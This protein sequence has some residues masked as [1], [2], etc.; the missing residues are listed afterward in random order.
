MDIYSL[1]L[2][3]LLALCAGIFVHGQSQTKPPKKPTAAPTPSSKP[4]SNNKNSQLPFLTVYALVMAS[5]WLQGPFLYPLYQDEHHL[6][7]GLISALFTTGFLSGAV[8]GAFIGSLA[9]KYGR[10]KACLF[11]CLSYA[12]SCLFTAFP[13][14]GGV[15]L[16]SKGAA[17]VFGRVL[18]GLSTSLLFSVFESWMVADFAAKGL[19]SGLSEMFGTMSMV[20]SLVAIASGVLSEWLVGVSGSKKAPFV[21]SMVLLCGAFGVISSSWVSNIT[22]NNSLIVGKTRLTWFMATG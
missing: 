18:G 14:L 5:D 3:A 20:N 7:H 1:N 12:L 4:T 6:P 2:T 13:S 8:S 19:E 10:K 15:F 21:A 9:D 11:F 22:H 16:L 17:L